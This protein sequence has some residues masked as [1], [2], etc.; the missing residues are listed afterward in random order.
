[1]SA[2]ERLDPQFRAL[3]AEI[4]KKSGISSPQNKR[5]REAAEHYLAQKRRLEE[6]VREKS[7]MGRGDDRRT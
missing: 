5:V 2:W 6:P 4:A 1:M 3:C 7:V